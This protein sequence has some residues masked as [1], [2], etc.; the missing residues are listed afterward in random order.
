MWVAPNLVLLAYQQTELQ[1]PGTAL[2]KVQVPIL[3]VPCQSHADPEPEQESSRQERHMA[4]L[5]RPMSRAKMYG[6]HGSCPSDEPQPHLLMLATCQAA[7]KKMGSQVG[8]CA[9]SLYRDYTEEKEKTP[10]SREDDHWTSQSLHCPRCLLCRRL[11]STQILYVSQKHK[12][13]KRLKR[14]WGREDHRDQSM[15]V[16]TEKDV[17]GKAQVVT[18]YREKEVRKH[19]GLS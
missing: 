13:Y 2:I 8:L 18:T 19:R 4:W 7:R 14:R 3:P 15:L 16:P 6:T 9:S 11:Y 10:P 1:T 12:M 5:A 17:P